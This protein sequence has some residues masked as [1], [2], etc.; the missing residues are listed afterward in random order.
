LKF[1]ARE[2]VLARSVPGVLRCG[3]AI[4]AVGN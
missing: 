4:V 2:V 1:R 3:A